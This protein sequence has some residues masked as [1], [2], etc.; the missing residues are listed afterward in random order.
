MAIS[1]SLLLKNLSGHIGKEL[2]FKRYGNKTVVAKYPK[3]E[4]ARAQS[5]PAAGE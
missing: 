1:E 4:P 3:Y 2:V 5:R